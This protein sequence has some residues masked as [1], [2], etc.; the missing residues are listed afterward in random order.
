M[1]DDV[2]VKATQII[3]LGVREGPGEINLRYEDPSMGEGHLVSAAFRLR[4]APWSPLLVLS[5]R[6]KARITFRTVGVI[7]V[8][9]RMEVACL[10]VALG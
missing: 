8:F 2:R 10:K 1:G 6:P 7:A 9:P 4:M 3:L 5:L